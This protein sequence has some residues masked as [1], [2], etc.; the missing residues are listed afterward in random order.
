[1]SSTGSG[2]GLRVAVVGAGIGGLATAAAL[3]KWGVRCDVYE[4]AEH[5]R[6]VGAGLQLAPNASAVLY[7][8]GLAE[9]L[10]RV[11]VRPA[12]VEMRRWDT[13]TLL[14][15]TELGAACEER[16]AAPYLTVHRADL[17]RILA[18]ACPEGS[19]HL[20]MRCAEVV[21]HDE[22]VRLHFA[23]GSERR[24]DVV[25]GADGIHSTVR[26]GLATDS[27]RY[28]GTMVYRGLA[29]ADRLP[30]HRDDPRVRLWLGPGQ[31]CVIY[32]VSEGD[33]VNV[34]ATVPG[35]ERT[36]ESWTARGDVADV[37]AAYA[38]WHAEVRE[39]LL[40]L[41]E[42]SLWALHDRDPLPSWTL[43][44]RTVL[45][46]AAHPMLPFLAQGANQ[47]IEDAAALA[48]C[49]GPVTCPDDVPAALTKYEAVR[50]DRTDTVH[51][52]ARRNNGMLHL[53]DG[54]EQRRRDAEL[55]TATDLSN[56]D[57]LYG[58]DAFTV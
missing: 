1:M 23:D 43:G 25:I 24:A 40:A 21:E 38:G 45:G 27:P 51:A 37:R 44:R 32:P 47:A 57:W 18:T 34:V 56:Q 30:R 5:L 2:P 9:P 42:V 3:K 4:Q 39:V 48:A 28:S 19:L 22:E 26:A 54:P 8:L 55:A 11:A 13:G 10:R 16:Y 29:P 20:A 36:Q 50:R 58:H 33:K 46:D 41:D 31:H 35:R 12:A 14:G 7:R 53:P 49:L 52:G 17:H 15:R 6:E